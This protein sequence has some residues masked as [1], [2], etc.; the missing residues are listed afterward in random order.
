MTVPSSPSS[1]DLLTRRLSSSPFPGKYS[2]LI[3]SY[4]LLLYIYP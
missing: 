3:T 1:A 2:N 4:V